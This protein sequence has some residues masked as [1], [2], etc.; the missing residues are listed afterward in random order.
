MMVAVRQVMVD[1]HRFA[2]HC[3][4]PSCGDEA[5][6][7]SECYGTGLLRGVK[8]A[9]NDGEKGRALHYLCSDV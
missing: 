7:F 1:G 9:R 8:T 4:E 3:E 5:I 6:V 2:C